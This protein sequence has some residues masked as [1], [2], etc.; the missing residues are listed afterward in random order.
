MMQMAHLAGMT[1]IATGVLHNVGNVLNSI[2]VSASLALDRLRT[3]KAAGVAKVAQLLNDR[4]AELAAF[5]TA[6][7][8]GKQLPTYLARL[9]ETLAAEQREVLEELTALAQNVE[10]V[11]RIV[12]MQQDHAK[13]LGVSETVRP[14]ELIEEAIRINQES[15]QRHHV[16]VKREFASLPTARLDKHQVLQILVNLIGNAKHAVHENAGERTLTVRLGAPPADSSRFF[17]AVGD[18]G[19]GIRPENLTRIFSHGY[20]TR[21]DGHGFGLHTSALSA[22][23][24]GGSLTAQSAG[25]GTGAVFTLELPLASP[26]QTA[27]SKA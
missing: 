12:S 3:S 14:E 1:E 22:Q 20:T 18:N 9:A 13:S 8:K 26:S 17:I 23:A 10:H 24:M 15:L 21:S 4:R 11:K 5:L 16:Q 2:N 7:E 25:L 27:G 6:D 19:V